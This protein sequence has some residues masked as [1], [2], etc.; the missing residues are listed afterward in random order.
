MDLEMSPG[1]LGN[2]WMI[3]FRWSYSRVYMNLWSIV[4]EY[5]LYVLHLDNPIRG[6][7]IL[8]QEG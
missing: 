3:Q 4:H 5:E 7:S 1:A 2:Q 8:Q 6:Q